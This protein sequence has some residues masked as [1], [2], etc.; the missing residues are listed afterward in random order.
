MTYVLGG[1]DEVERALVG[2]GGLV[3]DVL[4][5][6]EVVIVRR[7]RVQPTRAATTTCVHTERRGQKTGVRVGGYHRE[8]EE[9][10]EEEGRAD[11]GRGMWK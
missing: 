7:V 6:L 1:V 5:C 4:G 11:G 9:E 2:V 10:E 3:L 8:M